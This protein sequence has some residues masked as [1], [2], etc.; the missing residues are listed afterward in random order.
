[1][2]EVELLDE[3]C[4]TVVLAT[5][6]RRNDALHGR[7]EAILQPNLASIHCTVANLGDKGVCVTD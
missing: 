6:A 4:R 1:M 3:L 5:A 7:S 2:A